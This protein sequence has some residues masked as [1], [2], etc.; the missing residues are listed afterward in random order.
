MSPR[1][2]LTLLALVLA[3]CVVACSLS[4]L[5]NHLGY[6]NR[7]AMLPYLPVLVYFT[8]VGA[9]L[10]ATT[11]KREPLRGW[12]MVLSVGSS[13]GGLGTIIAMAALCAPGRPCRDD[14]IWW[15]LLV[16]TLV[17]FATIILLELK[18]RPV[19]N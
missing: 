2:R 9:R 17:L 15:A 5:L 3:G 7:V 14:P 12:K 18:C 19:S 1:E 13:L 6:S 16:V 4:F 11:P 8:A 10:Q